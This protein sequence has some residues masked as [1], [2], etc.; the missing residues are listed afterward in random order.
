MYH[1]ADDG[2]MVLGEVAADS[3]HLEQLHSAPRHKYFFL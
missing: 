1:T 3:P 2:V